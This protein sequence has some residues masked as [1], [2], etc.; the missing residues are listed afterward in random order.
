VFAF[1]QK[2][3][4][5]S[6]KN[7]NLR[8]TYKFPEQEIAI[9]EL[10][11]TKPVVFASKTSSTPLHT[12]FNTEGAEINTSELSPGDEVII[13]VLHR[14]GFYLTAG[15]TLIDLEKDSYGRIKFRMPFN[16]QTIKLTYSAQWKKGFTVSGFLL[17]L[18]ALLTILSLYI[19]K[20]S[21][22]TIKGDIN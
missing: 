14:P 22:M 20:K 12:T 4:E 13:G 15:N 9:Y 2:C 1:E 10:L 3:I 5:E 6:D 7:P 17:I 21:K 16:S 8:R 19:F 11:E 18:S